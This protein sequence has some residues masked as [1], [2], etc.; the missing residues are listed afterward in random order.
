G[1]LPA[2]PSPPGAAG[3]RLGAGR[4]RFPGCRLSLPRREARRFHLRH[5]LRPP[6]EPRLPGGVR[7][8]SPSILVKPFLHA[9]GYYGLARQVVT[10]FAFAWHES[11]FPYR[12]RALPVH[13]LDSPFPSDAEDEPYALLQ[14]RLCASVR[15]F[16]P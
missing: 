11:R 6:G 16:S 7:S 5:P 2:G 10:P 9:W 3:A 15:R 14:G 1:A 8:R 4:R 12:Y 13:T